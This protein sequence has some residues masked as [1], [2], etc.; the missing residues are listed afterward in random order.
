MSGTN[1]G[2]N[3]FG[4]GTFA[5]R[6]VTPLITNGATALY[7]ATDTAHLYAWSG[8]IATGLWKLVK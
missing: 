1:I 7:W 4:A 5:A 6:P 3:Y 2:S 8:P